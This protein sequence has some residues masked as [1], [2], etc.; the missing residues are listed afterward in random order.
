MVPKIRKKDIHTTEEI[1][2]EIA[3]LIKGHVELGFGIAI[4]PNVAIDLKREH[5][6]RVID[7]SHIF[8]PAIAS[9]ITHDE[10]PSRQYIS[11]FVDLVAPRYRGKRI[12]QDL[13]KGLSPR[14]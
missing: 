9:I 14:H 4:V 5:G 2:G 11:D 3:E 10:L 12:I 7:A 1:A 13:S 8:E 6:I